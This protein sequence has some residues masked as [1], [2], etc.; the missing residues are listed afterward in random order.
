MSH[1]C[2]LSASVVFVLY[3]YHIKIINI[4]RICFRLNPKLLKLTSKYQAKINLIFFPA[5]IKDAYSIIKTYK[6]CVYF[7][8]N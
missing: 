2:L 5:N 8:E 3:V 1:D 7:S 4:Y 6:I